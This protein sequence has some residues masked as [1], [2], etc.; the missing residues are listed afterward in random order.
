MTSKPVT[1]SSFKFKS[2]KATTDFSDDIRLT[3]E[4]GET[5][6]PTDSTFLHELLPFHPEARDKIGVGIKRFYVDKCVHGTTPFY[7]E[8]LDGTTDHFSAKKCIDGASERA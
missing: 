8:R 2:I 1:L 3:Y 4:L 6:N 5:I 7:I